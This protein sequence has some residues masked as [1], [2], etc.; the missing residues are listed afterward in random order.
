MFLK[1]QCFKQNA[2]FF[3]RFRLERASSLQV[4]ADVWVSV[5]LKK[6]YL[7]LAFNCTSDEISMR[8]FGLFLAAI[9]VVSA[10]VL[11]LAYF[12]A[13]YQGKDPSGGEFFFGVTYGQDTV[14]G[15]KLLIDKVQNYTNVFVVDSSPISH[16]ETALNAVC[17]YAA[18]KNLHF[19]V[20]FF[21][22]QSNL[23]Q[24]DWVTAA[25]QTWGDKFLGVY[26]RDEP[27]GRQIELAETVGVGNASSPSEAVNKYVYTLSS[28]E[29]SMK[30]LKD[31]QIPVVTSDFALY[32]Y[33][34]QAG[35][36]V[37]FA[38]LGWNNSRAQ[39]I[40]LCRGA[41]TMQEKD[42]GTIITWTYQHPPYMENG[43]EAYKDM[44]T[45]YEAGA[46]YILVFNYPRFPD[47]NQYGILF[48]EHFSAMQQFWDYVKAHPRNS[49]ESKG[50]VA[51]VLPK[52]HGGSL[53]SLDDK[54][55]GLWPADNASALIF[56]KVKAFVSKY[57]LKLDIIYDV[58][59]ADIT[60]TY[61]QVYFWN[62]TNLP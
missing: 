48:A 57:G 33:D 56:D 26:L 34:Y 59:T 45:S 41:A 32:W 60:E 51:L 31:R 19:I 39:E 46:K 38:Q 14:E 10:V 47:T 15:A 24:Q 18:E 22:V 5:F 27:G 17:S 50:E 37:V 11:P 12:S 23:W 9:L 62:Q 7:Q 4:L 44:V 42:W 61:S 2:W 54:I 1:I 36:D 52:D 6:I 58:E 13:S 16:N 20:Y 30:I 55:W 35:F 29:T 40:A 25:K 43:T 8:N 28:N 21:S 3:L 53:R 49:V